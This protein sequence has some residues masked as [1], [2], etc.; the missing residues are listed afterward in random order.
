M[1]EKIINDLKELEIDD[2]FKVKDELIKV[3]NSKRT[4][5]K[6]KLELA[7]NQYRGSGKCWVAN[8]DTDTKK[9]LN[10][11]NCESNVKEEQYKGYKVFLLEDG[12]Y[13]SCETGTKSN[14]KRAYFEIKNG[15]Y[16]EE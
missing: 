7:Y 16:I 15:E 8:V 14:D 2:L 4:S 5:S 11:I 3:I 1:I 9:I 13:L 12:Y 6:Y 10:F